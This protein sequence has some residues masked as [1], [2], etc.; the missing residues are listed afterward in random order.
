LFVE[1]KESEMAIDEGIQ[2]AMQEQQ[3]MMQQPQQQPQDMQQQ[4]M[5]PQ[6]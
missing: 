5:Q 4:P 2:Q 6:M 3:S 1:N